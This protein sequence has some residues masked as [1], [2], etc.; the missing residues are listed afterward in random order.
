[1]STFFAAFFRRRLSAGLGSAAYSGIPLTHRDYA[2][3]TIFLTGHAAKDEKC[4]DWNAIVTEKNVRFI[5][6]GGYHAPSCEGKLIP[7]GYCVGKCW[8]YPE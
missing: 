6:N 5:V 7:Q 8:R 3:G 4:I 1:M 2:S